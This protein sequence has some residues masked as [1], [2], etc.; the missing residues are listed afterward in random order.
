MSKTSS[1]D[2]ISLYYSLAINNKDRI[3]KR[4]NIIDIAFLSSCI[5]FSLLSIFFLDSLVYWIAPIGLAVAVLGYAE[6]SKVKIIDNLGEI[7]KE[8]TYIGNS[9]EL[10]NEI[11][12]V[13]VET[14]MKDFYLEHERYLNVSKHIQLVN[15]SNC[16][17]VNL[18]EYIKY[19]LVYKYTGVSYK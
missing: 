10:V 2:F 5:V 3:S 14:F 17:G 1:M 8:S 18:N 16:I 11:L 13:S 4:N 9:D 15:P 6:L 12:N 19:G 7:A